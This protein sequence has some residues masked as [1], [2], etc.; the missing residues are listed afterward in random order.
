MQNEVLIATFVDVTRFLFLIV[1]RS[2]PQ[3]HKVMPEQYG[4]VMTIVEVTSLALA[5]TF[6]GVPGFVEVVTFVGAVIFIV[7]VTLRE[8][9]NPLL[10]S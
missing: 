2:C 4:V 9:P 8:L 1:Q 3:F 5:V 6:I 7:D 10:M